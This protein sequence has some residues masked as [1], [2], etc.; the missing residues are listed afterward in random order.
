[1]PPPE[2]AERAESAAFS[3]V[4]THFFSF[5]PLVNPVPMCYNIIILQ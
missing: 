3:L 2:A 4:P 5:S 1:M